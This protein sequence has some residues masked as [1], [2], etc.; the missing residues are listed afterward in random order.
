M[1][2]VAPATHSSPTSFQILNQKS[3]IRKQIQITKAPNPKHSDASL[4]FVISNL[5][6]SYLFRISAFEFRIFIRHPFK[7]ANSLRN[8]SSVDMPSLVLLC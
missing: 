6:I 8:R 2:P 3:E 5:L 4:V 1:H 7:V